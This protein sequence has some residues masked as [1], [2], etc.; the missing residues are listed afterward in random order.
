MNKQWDN[1]SQR[2]AALSIRE[3][4]LVLFS[5]LAVFFMVIFTYLIEDNLAA[6]TKQ[7][8][9]ISQIKS[10]NSSM[11][12][13]IISLENTLLKDPDIAIKKQMSQY[14]Q[15]L[16]KV[17]GRLLKL[18]S[19]L[20]DPIQM[21]QALLELLNL[22]KGV[23]LLSFEVTPVEPLWLKN[24]IV[25]EP[26]EVNQQVKVS[27]ADKTVS[28]G[29]YRHSIKLILKGEYFHLRDYLQQ[30]EALSWTFFWHRFHY[31]LVEYP[32]SELEI[33]IYSL[34][35]NPEFIGV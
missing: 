19:D 34:S 30:L 8:Q 4:Y 25:D 22:E 13:T 21:R 26:L 33:E 27:T 16:V 15:R 2:Y 11:A 5:G 10:A 32:L 7:N 1:Y 6:I 24:D 18:T 35:T 17:E 29:L 14:E 3:Q 20:I 31:Q 9:E 23:K 12:N 28:S